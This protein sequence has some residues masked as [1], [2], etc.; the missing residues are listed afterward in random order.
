MYT[1]FSPEMKD[2]HLFLVPSMLPIHLT[3]LLF[4]FLK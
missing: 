4:P 3:I 2:T 1:K